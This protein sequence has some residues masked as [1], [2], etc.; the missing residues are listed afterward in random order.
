[1]FV[2][3]SSYRRLALFLL[4]F[5]LSAA[6]QQGTLV[7][8]TL[9]ILKLSTHGI[10]TATAEELSDGIRA[11]MRRLSV[12]ELIDPATIQS[13]LHDQNMSSSGVCNQNACAIQ[14]GQLLGADRVAIGSISLIDGTYSVNI[15]TIEINTGRIVNDVNEYY[16]GK[17]RYF[18]TDLIPVVAAKMSDTPV[19]VIKKRRSPVLPLVIIG[20]TVLIG[21]PIAIY[22]I[23]NSL[24]EKEGPPMTEVRVQWN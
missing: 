2:T 11:E 15:R 13:V 23:L 17:P 3:I 1:M 6:A 21:V 14:I 9:A 8:K 22:L 24:D 7:K 19:P 10:A 20:S 4:I 5:V 12:Y 16:S 18:Q